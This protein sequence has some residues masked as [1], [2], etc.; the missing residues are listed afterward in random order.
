MPQGKKSKAEREFEE[1][2]QGYLSGA[3]AAALAKP[4]QVA[5]RQK[6]PAVVAVA[7]PPVLV[8]PLASPDPEL[9]SLV[10]QLAATRAVL[11]QAQAQLATAQAQ[12]IELKSQLSV[13]TADRQTMDSERR[14]AGRKLTEAQREATVVRDALASADRRCLLEERGLADDE[15]VRA[16]LLLLRMYG[17]KAVD[18]LLVAEPTALTELLDRLVLSCNVA[19]CERDDA[20]LLEVERDRCE[21]CGGSD[22]RL[23][24][25]QWIKVLRQAAITRYTIVGGTPLYREMLR[26]MNR[27]LGHGL[28]LDTVGDLVPRAD[29]RARA[30][31]GLVVIWGATAV[32]HAVT[33][34]WKGK[35]D[36]QITIAHRGI[37]GMLR[38][39]TA[40]LL[41]TAHN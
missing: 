5:Q 9:Q 14:S 6:A 10:A 25:A 22:V 13:A 21:L 31:T 32:D 16:L 24:F 15:H 4:A 2:L 33:N 30:T 35:G 39:A 26:A 28:Q 3:P 11:A 8:A 27:E 41:R 38:L 18:A 23:A 12:A 20:P 1:Q 37:A 34:H 36:L 17:S 19:A 40:R 7:I 29:Q